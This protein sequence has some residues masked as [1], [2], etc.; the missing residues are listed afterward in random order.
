MNPTISLLFGV[1]AHQPVGNFTEVLDDAHQRCYGPFIRTLYR[2]PRFRF[3]AHFSGWLLDY[4]LRVYPED[5]ALLKH[6][7]TRG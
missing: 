5:M 6:M 7:V 4:M 1:H 3:A 2:Y